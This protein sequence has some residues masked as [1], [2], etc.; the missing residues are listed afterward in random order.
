MTS[1]GPEVTE[2]RLILPAG[3]VSWGRGKDEG[4]SMDDTVED[5][6]DG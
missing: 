5:R 2:G 1:W 3:E 6:R 4:R